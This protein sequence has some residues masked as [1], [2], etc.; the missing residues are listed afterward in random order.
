[1]KKFRKTAAIFAAALAFT[2][3]AGCGQTADSTVTEES[4]AAAV[5]EGGYKIGVIQYGSHPSL[6]N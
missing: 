5:S 4:S 2:A 1:M 6:D 3:F